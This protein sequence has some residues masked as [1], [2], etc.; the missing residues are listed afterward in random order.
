VNEIAVMSGLVV[1]LLL[2][3]GYYALKQIRTLQRTTEYHEMLPDDR[4]FLRR[5][6]WRRLLGSAFMVLL[7]AMMSGAYLT[8]L[9]ARADDLGERHLKQRAEGQPMSEEDK[10]FARIWGGYW[11]AFLLVLGGIVVI[12]GVDLMAT[13]RYG[14]RKLRQI[15]A[16]RRAMLQRQLER[17]R[18]ERGEAGDDEL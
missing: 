9:Q 18:Q 10:Q 13:R 6:A 11:I 8:D 15:Q 16:D 14:V 12:A 3:A 5:Q 1:V 7:A 2:L 4:S 17:Y